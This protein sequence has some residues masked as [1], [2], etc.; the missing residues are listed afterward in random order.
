[1]GLKGFGEKHATS[2]KKKRKK[3]AETYFSR[4]AGGEG[5]TG[6]ETR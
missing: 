4:S 1:M 5:A 3:G 2:K 6:Q